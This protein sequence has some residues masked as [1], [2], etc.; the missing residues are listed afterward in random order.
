M[1]RTIDLRGQRP[2]LTELLRLM[3]RSQTDVTAATGAAS[4]LISDVRARGEEALLDQAERFDGVRPERIRIHSE[5]IAAAITLLDPAVRD[6]LEE[7]IVRVR[8]ASRTQ[9]PESSV[10]SL[11]P[12]ADVIQRWSPVG[13]VGL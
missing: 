12:G 7:A 11:G 3:P 13:R 10:T 9:V 4:A 5:E 1:I 2:T 8:A 6:A